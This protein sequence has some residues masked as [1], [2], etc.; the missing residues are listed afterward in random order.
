MSMGCLDIN[1]MAREDKKRKRE[2]GEELRL[3]KYKRL[4]EIFAD[5]AASDYIG[6]NCCCEELEDD[7]DWKCPYAPLFIIFYS[8]AN[9]ICNHQQAFVI[10]NPLFVASLDRT[11]TTNR[12]V[13]RI[14]TP[15]LMAARINVGHLTLSTSSNYSAVRKN[16]GAEIYK[17]F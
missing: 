13:I 15:A 7:D 10:D 5:M 8:H 16:V 9:N 11:C 6:N 1:F 4:N 14:I 17:D 2:M 12:E 3:E